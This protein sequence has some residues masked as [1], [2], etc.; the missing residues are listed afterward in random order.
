MKPR[1][2]C[3]GIS[4]HT[5]CAS[6]CPGRS[7]TDTTGPSD[8][9]ATTRATSRRPAER[10][11]A[12]CKSPICPPWGQRGLQPVAH[13]PAPGRPAW[14]EAPRSIPSR[15]DTPICCSRQT[16]PG[17]L[18]DTSRLVRLQHRSPTRPSREPCWK[19]PRMRL[20]VVPLLSLCQST[21]PPLVHS[22]TNSEAVLLP[23]GS[24]LSSS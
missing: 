15:W 18:G 11:R 14:S 19:S 23:D 7:F 8:G 21:R 22:S 16:C 5:S 1:R 13:L 4:F 2:L 12:P 3:W 17:Y 10:R 24:H 6:L 20:L 9:A